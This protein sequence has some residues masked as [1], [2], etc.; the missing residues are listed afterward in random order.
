MEW[1][2]GVGNQLM[3]YMGIDLAWK[4]EGV[5][6]VAIIDDD[7]NIIH[8]SSKSYSDSDLSQMVSSYSDQIILSIDSP[9]QVLNDNGGRSCDSELMKHPFHKKYLK[10]FAT[11][12]N[13]MN[14]QYG[15]E[16]IQWVLLPLTVFT[17]LIV[18]RF[19][20]NTMCPV[21]FVLNGITK[22]RRYLNRLCIW[23]KD[24][25]SQA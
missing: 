12:R 15:G 16:G 25:E 21:G 1:E 8:C 10:V 14:K 5:S 3:T 9:L 4:E 24:P 18:R 20:C 19:Y 2:P 11:S 7:K 13:Y 17:A 23:K 22:F 6:G